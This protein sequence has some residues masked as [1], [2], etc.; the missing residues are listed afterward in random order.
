MQHPL[1]DAE[2][3]TGSKPTFGNTPVLTCRTG[4]DHRKTD[5]SIKSMSP[6]SNSMYASAYV[7]VITVRDHTEHQACTC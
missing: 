2:Q 1:L 7:G 4:D 5:L 6:E 3:R